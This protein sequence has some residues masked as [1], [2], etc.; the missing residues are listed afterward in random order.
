MEMKWI[1]CKHR[2]PTSVDDYL[3]EIRGWSNTSKYMDV[4]TF[5]EGKFMGVGCG[6]AVTHWMPLP[7]P[8]ESE[9]GDE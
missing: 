3:V 4:R 7:A 6:F 1:D 5:A 2:M 8:P 9:A